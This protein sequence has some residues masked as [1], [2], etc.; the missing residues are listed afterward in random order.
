[1]IYI[2]WAEAV[3]CQ[4][5]ALVGIASMAGDVEKTAAKI[6]RLPEGFKIVSTQGS[7][8]IYCAACNQQARMLSL[9]P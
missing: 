9:D 5:C 1:M 4:H 7:A 2:K 8:K 6:D 3:R